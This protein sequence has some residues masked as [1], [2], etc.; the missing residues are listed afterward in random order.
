MPF[1]KAKLNEYLPT[2]LIENRQPI[3]AVID[4]LEQEGFLRKTGK[5]SRSS[6][7]YEKIIPAKY[8]VTTKSGTSVPIQKLNQVTG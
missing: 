5:K 1:H 8:R 4:V 3:K 2:R 6:E 7:E